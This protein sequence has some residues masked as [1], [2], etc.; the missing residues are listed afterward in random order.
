LEPLRNDALERHDP[1]EEAIQRLNLELGMFECQPSVLDCQVILAIEPNR[2][3]VHVSVKGGIG[4]D[5]Y[6]RTIESMGT[7]PLPAFGTTISVADLHYGTHLN[8]RRSGQP[9]MVDFSEERISRQAAMRRSGDIS[10][11]ELLDR[12]AVVGLTLPQVSDG[13]AEWMVNTMWAVIEGRDDD[14]ALGT[15]NTPYKREIGAS[16]LARCLAS[17]DMHEPVAT[18]FTDVRP[19]LEF[20]E[21]HRIPLDR[22]VERIAS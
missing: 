11:S 2:V 3:C 13:E 9:V 16:E 15:V 5:R 8:P 7:A 19:S 6:Y 21:R 4:Q 20:A 12:I 14:L 18:F 1:S 22:L 17:G 10:Y